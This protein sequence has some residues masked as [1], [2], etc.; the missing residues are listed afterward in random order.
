VVSKPAPVPSR[1]LV[2]RAAIMPSVD[3]AKPECSSCGDLF[4]CSNYGWKWS[5]ISAKSFTPTCTI[6]LPS[7][8]VTS[9]LMSEA[10]RTS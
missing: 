3:Q 7:A 6:N 8:S 2:V 4:G 5:L 9:L 10:S 1:N